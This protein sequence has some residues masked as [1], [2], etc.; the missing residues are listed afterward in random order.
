MAI[1]LKAKQLINQA[2]ETGSLAVPSHMAW[3]SGSASFSESDTTLGSEIV[4]NA[5]GTTDRQSTTIE[6]TSTLSSGQAN[7][8]SIYE[9]GLFNAA[10]DGDMFIREVIY[11]VN[12]TSSFEYDAVALIRVK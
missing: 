4:R 10:T 5:V 11:P 1:T 12:K 9:I 7:G 2:L 8:E 3:G 6:W